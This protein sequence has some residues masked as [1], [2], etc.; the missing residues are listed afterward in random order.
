MP[1]GNAI[2]PE[3]SVPCGGWTIEK[4][5]LV[6]RRGENTAMSDETLNFR[7]RHESPMDAVPTVVGD[8]DG[9]VGRGDTRRL[10]GR[11]EI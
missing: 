2:G 11:D 6:A 8:V 5:A 4:L 9:G 1:G 3:A 10:S 7:M